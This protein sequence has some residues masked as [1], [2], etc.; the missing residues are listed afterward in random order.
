MDD[1]KYGEKDLASL[2][3]GKMALIDSG[4]TSI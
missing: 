1:V 3:G 4:N 2:G